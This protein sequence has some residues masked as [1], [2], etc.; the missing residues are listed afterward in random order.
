MRMKLRIRPNLFGAALEDCCR[1][2]ICIVQSVD[3][4]TTKVVDHSPET[5]QK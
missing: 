5:H 1:V 3:L 4:C 2:L